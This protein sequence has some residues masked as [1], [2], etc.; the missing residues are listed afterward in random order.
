MQGLAPLWPDYTYLCI[1]VIYGSST[2][3]GRSK[4]KYDILNY[5]KKVTSV[6]YF[7][8]LYVSQG[9]MNIGKKDT[10]LMEHIIFH[11]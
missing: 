10:P 9:K 1:H 4:F 7:E 8:L 3:I 5:K 2:K 6:N 11:S